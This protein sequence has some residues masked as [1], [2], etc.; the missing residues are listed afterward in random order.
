MRPNKIRLH[1]DIDEAGHV[2]AASYDVHHG[3]EIV[4]IHVMPEAAPFDTPAAVLAEVLADIVD[5]Y[6][7]RLRIF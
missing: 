4:A 3:S 5:R 1:L 7:V 2:Y 6:G